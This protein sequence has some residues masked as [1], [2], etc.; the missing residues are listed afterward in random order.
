ML[1]LLKCSDNKTGLGVFCLAILPLAR[2]LVPNPQKKK[3]K[4]AQQKLS[5]M[6][7]GLT[8][9]CKRT[10][11]NDAAHIWNVTPDSIKVA[12]SLYSAKKA[13]KTFVKT[14]PF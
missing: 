11:L 6:E 7:H 12:K 8:D 10:F 1:L 2:L 4:K 5:T 9:L 3:K 14:L 13:I